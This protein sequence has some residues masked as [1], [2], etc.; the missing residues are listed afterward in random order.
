MEACPHKLLACVPLLLPPLK[1]ALDTQQPIILATT[2]KIFQNFILADPERIGPAL[3][4]FYHHFLGASAVFNKHKDTRNNP[5]GEMDWGQRRRLCVSD[6]VKET[7]ELLET[8]GG[9]KAFEHIRYMIPGYE[10]V[11]K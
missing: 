6:L 5:R 2:L 9:R 7:L 8:T 3:V 11:M 10:S 1:R 4:P